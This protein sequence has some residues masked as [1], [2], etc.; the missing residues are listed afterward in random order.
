[1]NILIDI[2]SDQSG[3]KYTMDHY[4]TRYPTNT[5]DIASFL[6]RLAILVKKGQ[7]STPLPPIIQYTAPEPFTKY[8]MCLIFAKI[9]GLSLAHI[10]PDDSD[11]PAGS[12]TRPKDCKLSTRVI[13]EDLKMDVAACIFEDYWTEALKK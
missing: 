1:M 13:E 5:L 8:E 7:T 6:H 3:K 9:R 2:V 4:A 12:V 11:P 10:T